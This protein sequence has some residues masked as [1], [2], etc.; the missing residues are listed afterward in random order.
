MIRSLFLAALALALVVPA[1]AQEALV[2]YADTLY[3]MAGAPIVDGAVVIE[4][5]RIVQV[6]PASQV[7]APRGARELR[8]VVVTP[9]L[10]DVR[11]TVGLSGLLNQPQDQDALDR[12]KPL[13]PS[14]RAMDAY[15]AR[16]GLVEWLLSLG[17]TTVHTGHSP[18]ALAAGQTTI[19]K[20]A[21]LTLDEALVDSTTMMAMTVGPSIHSY[22]DAPGTR[23]RAIAEIRSALYRGLAH[24][25]KMS[26]DTAPSRDL[27]AEALAMVATGQ[28]PALISANRANDI[29][30]VLR[31]AREFPQMDLVLSGAAEAHLI[32]DEIAEAG[33]PVVLHPTMAR[34]GGEREAL[35]FDTAAKLRQRGIPFAIQSGYEAYVPKTRVVLFEAA[36]AAAYGLAREHALEAITIEAATI[37]GIDDRVGSLEVGKDA[38]LVLF[39]G[40]PL[41]TITH[42]CSVVVDG[43]VVREEACQGN[44]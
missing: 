15:N 13:Q 37:L 3:T 43:Q 18:G 19:V 29:L 12:G 41:E 39:D 8:G 25:E 20:T 38:D 36:V 31:L 2:V 11:G 7:R 23:S 6:G 28:M 44:L 26:D 32:L 5:G 14:L 16:D 40:D 33:V 35:A 30:T 17:V 1:S 34:A 4:E 27:D 10:V 24:A 9:G 42:V 22:F 21:Y